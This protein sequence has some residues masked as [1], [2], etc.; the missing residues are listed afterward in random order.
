LT[1][2]PITGFTVGSPMGLL[3]S[4]TYYTSSWKNINNFSSIFEKDTSLTT[5]VPGSPMGLLL[6]LTVA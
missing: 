1:K 4:L 6:S 5:Q 3:L 2:E